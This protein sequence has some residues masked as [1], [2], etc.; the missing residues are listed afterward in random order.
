[1]AV[2][3]FAAIDIGSYEVSMKILELSSKYGMKEIDY[4]RHG[5]ELGKDAYNQKE[6]S[7]SLIHI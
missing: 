1:M 5:L 6:I 7:L 4:I 2:M 3:T